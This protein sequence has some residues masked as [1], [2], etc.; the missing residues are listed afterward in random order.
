MLMPTEK[1]FFAIRLCQLRHS[2]GLTQSALATKAGLS[3]DAVRQFEYGRREPAFATL[4]KLAAGLG[5]SLSA[6]DQPEEPAKPAGKAPPAPPAEELI[7]T[8][9]ARAQQQGGG[10]TKP[11]G[12]K[13]SKR[14][15]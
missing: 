12:R 11:K 4:V 3:I 9:R 1:G 2:A 8:R 6:F 14:E 5:V 10:P 13:D 7:Q 15:K